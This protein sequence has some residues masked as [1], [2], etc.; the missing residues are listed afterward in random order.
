MTK[1]KWNFQTV[2]LPNHGKLAWGHR[3]EAL[4]NIMER[5]RSGKL[6][7]R[8]AYAEFFKAR[9]KGNLPGLGPAFFTKLI[10]FLGPK[11]K[12]HI[13]D[14]YGYIMDQ[15]TAKST[16]LLF[17]PPVVKIVGSWVTPDNDEGVYEEFCERVEQIAKLLGCCGAE[18]ERQLFSQR[19]PKP[20]HWRY[21][22]QHIPTAPSAAKRVHCPIF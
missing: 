6:R 22:V 12:C 17:Q 2:P 11:H 14:Q 4:L 20:T 8:E 5:I 1:I 16:N 21:Y 18:A 3:G 10:F 9:C 15:W 19:R 7:R 13:M